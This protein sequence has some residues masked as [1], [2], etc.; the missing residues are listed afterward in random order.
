MMQITNASLPRIVRFLGTD[1][2]PDSSCPHCG[3]TGRYIHRFVVEDGRTLA[4]M[5]GCA[6]LF[7]CSRVATEEQRLRKKQADYAKRGWSLNRVDREALEAVESFYAGIFDER[8]ALA[9]IDHA[10]RTNTMRRGRR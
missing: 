7:P 6:K 8:A 3:C 1:D 2:C 5:S 4:A 10:K 9:R